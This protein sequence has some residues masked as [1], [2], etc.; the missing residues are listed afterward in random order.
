M[1]VLNFLLFAVRAASSVSSLANRIYDRGCTSGILLIEAFV[2][3]DISTSLTHL[4]EQSDVCRN[5]KAESTARHGVKIRMVS[6]KQHGRNTSHFN[7]ED[8][9]SP[10]YRPFFHPASLTKVQCAIK[11]T[12]KGSVQSV[13][14]RRQWGKPLDREPQ[15]SQVKVDSTRQFPK[16]K[17]CNGN[18][19]NV[20]EGCIE[21]LRHP[22]QDILFEEYR[23]QR[24]ST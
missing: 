1:T 21:P 20:K 22:G 6:N 19:R 3:A 14:C 17:F 5:T 10:V 16:V 7:C 11:D 18:C 13:V 15:A 24:D 4:C 12:I 23:L 8:S 9:S 2:K